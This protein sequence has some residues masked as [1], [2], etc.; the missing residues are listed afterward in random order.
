MSAT[1]VVL[2]DGREFDVPR[3]I[4]SEGKEAIDR[5]VDEQANPPKAKRARAEAAPEVVE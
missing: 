3:E 4:E 1:K 5:W 2:G